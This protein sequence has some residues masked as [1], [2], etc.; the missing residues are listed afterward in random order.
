MHQSFE[1]QFTHNLLTPTPSSPSKRFAV[2]RNNVFVS[3]VEALKARFPAIQNAVGQDFFSAMARD[4]AASHKPTSPLMMLY[5][6]SFPAYIGAFAPLADYPYMADLAR[7][8]C[9]ITKSY[10]SADATPLGA[11]AF[12]CIAPETLGQLRFTLHPALNL[13]PSPFPIVTLWQM[14]SG[15]AEIKPLETLCA[16]TALIHRSHLTVSVKAISPAGGLFL[17]ALQNGLTL[18]DAADIALTTD[19]AFDLSSH[20]HLLIADGL[21]TAL[22]LD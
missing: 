5:G 14:N 22:S 6:E 11:Q 17:S 21:V 19:Q 8:E 3:L 7:L 16:E 18:S 15:L 2:Y 20:L 1:T 13:I 12:A 10:H 4:Y 9:A